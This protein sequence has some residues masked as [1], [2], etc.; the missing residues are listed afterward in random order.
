MAIQA[1]HRMMQQNVGGSRGTR[2]A[3]SSDDSIGGKRHLD[4]FALKPVIQKIRG[5]LREYFYES[6]DLAPRQAAQ[7]AYELYVIDK[8]ADALWW[9][10]R[11]RD[12]QQRFRHH[13]EFFKMRFV[14][15][16]CLGIA[17]REF[18][19]LGQRLRAILPHEQV[20]PVGKR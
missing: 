13:S 4:F 19:D 1:A 15:R 17:L 20:T 10:F 12:Q 2:T 8:I 14:A 5:A 18:G 9:E 6:D 7:L 3:V 16:K 11:W